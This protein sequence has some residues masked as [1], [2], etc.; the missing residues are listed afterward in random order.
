MFEEQLDREDERGIEV[1]LDST[2]RSTG[3][4]RET[5]E[6]EGIREPF[7]PEKIDVTTRT[8]TVDLLLSRIRRGVLDLQPEFQRLAGIWNQQ[9]QSRLIES[10]LLRIPLPTFYAAETEDERWIMVD[11]IQRLTTIARFI[12]P[13]SIEATPL[14]LKQLEYL[15]PDY[16][17]KRFAD[18]PG[19]LQTRLLETEVVVHLIRQ[20]TP[21]PVMFNIF[22]RINTGGRP[23]TRQEL[24][25]ALIPGPARTLLKEWAQSDAYRSATLGSVS[26]ERMD[27]REMALRFIAFRLT[28]PERYTR[29]DFD[30]FLREAMHELNGLRG[31]QVTQLHAEFVRAMGAAQ[32]IFGPYAF[33]KH[34]PGS[35]RRSPINKA[36]FEAVAVNLAQRSKPELAVLRERRAKVLE[37]Y[38]HLM[39]RSDFERAIS[40]G[41]GD[42]AKVRLR[43][44]AID[45]LLQ[46]VADD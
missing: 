21:E 20:G 40:Q 32:A 1:E 15:G 42:I 2:G 35:Q 11:G 10:M 30:D 37:E 46:E 9:A 22:A 25:H 13:E 3:V 6:D 16:E 14:T 31:E 24:R 17:G 38:S 12:T 5:S 23:L 28:Q 34:Y 19:R 43:F 27:D 45:D 29:R 41:T 7:D 36:L 18:L 44:S 26:P 4:E 8:P 39:M 33:R